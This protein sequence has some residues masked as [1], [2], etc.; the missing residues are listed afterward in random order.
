MESVP[1][2][3]AIHARLETALRLENKAEVA[4]KLGMKRN[5][6]YNRIVGNSPPYAE[7]INLC[8]TENM[9]L[10]WVILGR[11]KPFIDRDEE[12]PRSIEADPAVL[13][14]AAL[15]LHQK[16]HPEA[17]EEEL[18][19]VAHLAGLAAR[20]HNIAIGARSENDRREIISVQAEFVVDILGRKRDGQP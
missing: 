16:L 13:S 18:T 20:I 2:A 8:I 12:A 9:C 1:S 3:E 5:A 4:E 19:Q 7:I 6:Y 14:E 17:D 11:G 15:I 10:D